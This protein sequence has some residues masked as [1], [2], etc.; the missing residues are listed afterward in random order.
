MQIR[1]HALQVRQGDLPVQDHLVQADHEVRIQEPAVEN[2]EADTTPNKLEIVEMFWVDSRCRVNL[3]GV[4]VMRGVFEQAVEGV[5]HFVREEEEEFS[6]HICEFSAVLQDRARKQYL[7]R[8][9]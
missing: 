6:A 8:P 4:V 2:T 5:E 1:I 9:P 3:E 7:E